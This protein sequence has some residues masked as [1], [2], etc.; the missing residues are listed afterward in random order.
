M[1]NKSTIQPSFTSGEIA[2]SLWGRLDVSR[3]Y[4]GLKTCYNFI[5]RQFGGVSNRPGTQYS[6][7]VSN[8]N[9]KHRNVPFQFST[10]QAYALVFGNQKFRI[11]KDGGLVLYPVGHPS[12]GQIVEVTT[13]FLE[14]DLFDLIYS[15]SADVLT[16]THTKYPVQ[17]ITRTDHHLIFLWCSFHDIVQHN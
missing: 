9:V 7:D 3:Y 17:Q 1:A 13:P 5:V 6:G 8:H 10:E 11:I 15:Q 4:T 16:V 12:A 14:A 2:P